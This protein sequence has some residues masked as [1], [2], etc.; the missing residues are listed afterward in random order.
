[1]L[2]NIVSS[3]K[4][5]ISDIE[6]ILN[7]IITRNSIH[8]GLCIL[9]LNAQQRTDERSKPIIDILKDAFLFA[10]PKSRR[11]VER[12]Q[13]RKFGWPE[14]HWKPLVPKTN[15]LICTSCGHDYL[16]GHLCGNCYERVK[17]E[18]E[19]MQKAIEATLKLDP[20]EKEVVVLYEDELNVL[21]TLLVYIWRL[22]LPLAVYG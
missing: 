21:F 22:H 7:S 4:Y 9:P 18:T 15:I 11:S 5:L 16:A 10:V 14:Y 17:K 12:R 13:K 19:E 8:P 20:V 3:C 6:N 2:K 1:M